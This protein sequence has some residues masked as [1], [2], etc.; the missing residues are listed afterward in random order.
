M[1]RSNRRSIS[2]K[3]LRWEE[4]GEKRRW[5]LGGRSEE[6][7]VGEG[8]DQ[9][10]EEVML[11]VHLKSAEKVSLSA[12][13]RLSS[14]LSVGEWVSPSRLS[15][16]LIHLAPSFSVYPQ[17][18]RSRFAYGCVCAHLLNVVN[19]SLYS[20]ELYF[21]THSDIVS[22]FWHNVSSGSF[23]TCRMPV[24]CASIRTHTHILGIQSP[25]TEWAQKHHGPL[26]HLTALCVHIY[27]CVCVLLH[28]AISCNAS[29][30][31]HLY[32]S[33]AFSLQLICALCLCFFFFF[34]F[35]LLS[36]DLGYSKGSY[37]SSPLPHAYIISLCC[38]YVCAHSFKKSG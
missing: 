3:R 23:I 5:M 11:S 10:R 19:E 31:L 36:L 37:K 24:S 2:Q 6:R 29:F 13:Y 1:K 4:R 18:E 9:L 22:N 20:S 32:L 17:L 38:V 35:I 33:P 27:M 26:H 28:G 25:V 8:W 30:P 16:P 21:E 7:S 34:S 12:F 14:L 15:S